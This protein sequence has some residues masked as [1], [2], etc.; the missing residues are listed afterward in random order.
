MDPKRIS[1]LS[2]SA[3]GG[4]DSNCSQ[5]GQGGVVVLSA[6]GATERAVAEAFLNSPNPNVQILAASM[7]E[8]NNSGSL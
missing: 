1:P 2:V 6:T 4:N 8:N 7:A 5:G 3:G